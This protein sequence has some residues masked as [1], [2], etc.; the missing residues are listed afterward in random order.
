MSEQMKNC[1][2]CNESIAKNAKTCPHCGAKNKTPFFKKWWFWTIIAII[3]IIAIFGGSDSETVPTNT[4]VPDTTVQTS[5]TQDEK[6]P[7]NEVQNTIADAYNTIAQNSDPKFNINEKAVSFMSAHSEYFPG[8][9]SIKGA[10]SDLVDN[11]I[12][13]AHLTKNINK[14]GDKLINVSGDVI[15]IFESDDGTVT[16]LHL[17]DYEGNNFVVYYLGSLDNVFEGGY[18]WGYALPLDIISF[19]NMGG[20]YTEAVVCAGCYIENPQN[21]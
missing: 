5:D 16:Y 2:V 11:E 7:V 8:N 18:T 17:S 6:E 10:I 1:K 3:A 4:V 14:Y 15:D 21:E 20:T 12:T 19:E 13:Y 9:D